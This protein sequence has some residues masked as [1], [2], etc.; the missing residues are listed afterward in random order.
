MG[1]ILLVVLITPAHR[2]HS[3]LGGYSKEWGY[4]PAGGLG[5]VLVI[6]LVLGLMNYV[7]MWW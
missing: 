7:P 4:Y 3:Q 2:L 6:I 5:V 1:I